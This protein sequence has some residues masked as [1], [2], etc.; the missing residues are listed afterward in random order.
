MTHA[1]HAKVSG[2]ARA[3]TSAGATSIDAAKQATAAMYR[4]LLQQA[5][6]LAYLDALYILGFAAALMDAHCLAD[7]AAR[8]DGGRR[9]ISAE[10]AYRTCLKHRTRRGLSHVPGV[11]ERAGGLSH[12]PRAPGRA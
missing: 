2:I 10:L 12:V 7:E 6:Q 4:Q 8:A 1:Y 9:R 5:S 11:T 3:M